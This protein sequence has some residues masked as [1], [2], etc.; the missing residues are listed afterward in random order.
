MG[1]SAMV[2]GE[3]FPPLT[4]S[5]MTNIFSYAIQT[6]AAE[7]FIIGQLIWLY[8]PQSICCHNIARDSL[9]FHVMSSL[10]CCFVL[11]RNEQLMDANDDKKGTKKRE[12]IEAAHRMDF[13]FFNVD[14]WRNTFRMTSYIPEMESDKQKGIENEESITFD[15]P[16]QGDD[17]YASIA[18]LR[19]KNGS[20]NAVKQMMISP[21]RKRCPSD[22][23]IVVDDEYAN[24]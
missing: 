19:S 6:C 7:I 15:I 13:D 5:P 22:E 4:E 10:E 14:T 24:V 20:A 17:D 3:R 23:E 11:E 2:N 12:E 9:F 16:E 8:V 21:K 1:L 18:T